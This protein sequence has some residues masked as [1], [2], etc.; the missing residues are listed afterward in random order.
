M[1]RPPE[2][3]LGSGGEG[4]WLE[5]GQMMT[6]AGFLAVFNGEMRPSGDGLPRSY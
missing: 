6:C 1:E 4:H 2:N 5:S 3:A